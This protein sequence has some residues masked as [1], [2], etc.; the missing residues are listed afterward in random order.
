MDNTNTE[1]VTLEISSDLWAEL[2]KVAQILGFA[3]TEDAAVGAISEWV[4]RRKAEI[5]D[6]DPAQ[7]YFVNE[8]LDELAGQSK[9]GKKN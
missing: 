8:A 5:E 7:R 3:N 9:S 4:S 6:R 1:K 2:E